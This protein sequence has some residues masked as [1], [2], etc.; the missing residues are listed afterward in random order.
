MGATEPR[1]FGIATG[2]CDKLQFGNG[3]LGDSVLV[4]R[5]DAHTWRVASRATP[6]DRAYCVANAQTYHMQVDLVVVSSRDLP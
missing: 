1:F 3:A 2:R 4:T 6:N 5:V